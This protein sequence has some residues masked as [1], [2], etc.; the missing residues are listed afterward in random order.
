MINFEALFKV[1]YGMYI[2]C[3]GSSESGNG[4]ISNTVFQVTSDPPKFATACNKENFTAGIIAK[5][6]SFSVSVLSN[7]AA[8]ELFG[9][10]GY[11]SGKDYNKLQGMSVKYG[12]TGVPIV[13]NDAVAVFECRLTDTVDAGSHLIFIGE[14]IQSEVIEDTADPLTY[15]EYRRVRKGSAP[16][17]APTYIDRSKLDEQRNHGK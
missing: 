16:K 7:K 4:Y 1:S 15:L 14:I 9:R 5:T 17:N 11:R 13:L 6:G 2:V 10:F 3:S 8:P 12:E